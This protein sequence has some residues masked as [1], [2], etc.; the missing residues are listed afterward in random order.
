[1]AVDAIKAKI[2][3]AGFLR[4]IQCPERCLI[5]MPD[6]N[7]RVCL[8]L[9]GIPSGQHLQIFLDLAFSGAVPFHFCV[10]AVVNGVTTG[11]IEDGSYDAGEHGFVLSL[12]AN[13]L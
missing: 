4:C 12:T 3:S 9:S 8:K 7:A 6:Q 13:V 11:L 5:R 10:S 1:M 2:Q